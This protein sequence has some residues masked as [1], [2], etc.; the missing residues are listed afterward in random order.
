VEEI[1]DRHKV[2]MI[3][4]AARV[5]AALAVLHKNGVIHRDLKT[6]NIMYDPKSGNLKLIDFGFSHAI[7]N[8]DEAANAGFAPY[9]CSIEEYQMYDKVLSSQKSNSSNNLYQLADKEAIMHPATDVYGLGIQTIAFL[10]GRNGDGT[11]ESHFPSS[12]YDMLT[13]SK[14]NIER[15]QEFVKCISTTL[16]YLNCWLPPSAQYTQKQL[17]FIEET[18]RWCMDPNPTK[19]PPAAPAAYAMEMFAAGADDFESAAKNAIDDRPTPENYFP[20]NVIDAYK[21][22]GIVPQ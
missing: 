4:I 2:E 18:I 7:G 12:K 11:I 20:Q 9:C 10:F 17:N 3:L 22:F 21:K 19:R 5:A 13:Y 16:E 1:G 15:R 8:V 6:P 14:Y